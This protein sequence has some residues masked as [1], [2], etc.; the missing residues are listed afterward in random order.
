MKQRD[1][2]TEG[3]SIPNPGSILPRHHARYAAALLLAVVALSGVTLRTL[4]QDPDRALKRTTAEVATPLT[5]GGWYLFKTMLSVILEIKSGAGVPV[6]RLQSWSF[7]K[8]LDGADVT[9]PTPELLPEDVPVSWW[10][11]LTKEEPLIGLIVLFLAL[12]M[13]GLLGTLA[14]H[15]RY[16]AVSRMKRAPRSRVQR[17]SAIDRDLYALLSDAPAASPPLDRTAPPQAADKAKSALLS[18]ITVRNPDPTA[19]DKKQPAQK[20]RP[21]RLPS[22]DM[23]SEIPIKRAAKPEPSDTKSAA[24]SVPDPFS[25]APPTRPES[26]RLRHDLDE[27]KGEMAELSARVRQQ[28]K[29]ADAAQ[30]RYEEFSLWQRRA[31]EDVTELITIL[32][33]EVAQTRADLAAM[34]KRQEELERRQQMQSDEMNKAST[35]TAEMLRAEIGSVRAELKELTD[36]SGRAESLDSFYV[37]TL[38]AILGQNIEELQDGNFEQ[39]S[40]HV[41]ERLNQFFQTE[42]PRGDKLQGLRL[43]AEAINAALKNLA[44]QMAK[45]NPQAAE[46]ANPHLER[47]AGLAA[48]LGRLQTQLETRRASVET[49]LR[50]PVSLHAGARQSFLEELARGIRREVAKL[51][52]PQS[53]YEGHLEHLLTADI[54]PVV[55]ICDKKLAHPGA[56]PE[57]EAALDELFAQAGLSPIL[58]R[59][60]EPYKVAEQEMVRTVQGGPGKSLIIAQVVTRGFFYERQDG[61]ALL[62]KAGVAV[63]R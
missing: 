31:G 15:I 1:A 44:A 19:S 43:R 58:P 25:L 34:K 30:Q 2:R 23:L 56:R 59:Q 26:S 52:E 21:R 47:V 22:G 37:K 46:E 32:K 20:E 40:R 49:T 10:T 3:E 8:L 55:D 45:L 63:Y 27:L 41:G 53:Y 60:G 18:R 14:Q 12:C 24:K 51:S 38:G 29:V 4:A 5:P 11:Y 42:A 6:S 28:M 33:N 50:I 36:R 17:A 57:L 7:L 62:R 16:F 39:L 35:L 61:R 9:S 54:I 48:E 13:I